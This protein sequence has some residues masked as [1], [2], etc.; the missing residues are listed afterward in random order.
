MF[1]PGTL[2]A[3]PPP[4]NSLPPRSPL[5][6][7]AVLLPVH[8]KNSQLL[9]GPATAPSASQGW[10]V[11]P[12]PLKTNTASPPLL[13]LPKG[14][15]LPASTSSFPPTPC[16]LAGPS[17]Q[18]SPALAPTA[19]PPPRMQPLQQARGS[20]GGNELQP[21][22]QP[23]RGQRSGASCVQ[24]LP[25]EGT[26]NPYAPSL[27]CMAGKHPQHYSGH[28]PPLPGEP[29]AIVVM[30]APVLW[31]EEGGRHPCPCLTPKPQ[32]TECSLHRL[33]SARNPHPPMQKGPLPVLYSL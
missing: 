2:D 5:P 23:S 9:T 32:P 1:T 4:A 33:F 26:F 8:D 10:D 20:G 24:M 25:P 29:S 22:E 7:P 31:A 27:R 18:A 17:L 3:P 13:S 11:P 21:A 30:A 19:A 6:L 12:Q 16:S 15:S 28:A 14:T